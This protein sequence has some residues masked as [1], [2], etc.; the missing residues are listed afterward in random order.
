MA[1]IKKSITVEY[2]DNSYGKTEQKTKVFS[3]DENDDKQ[4][5]LKEI[6]EWRRD[7]G[8]IIKNQDKMNEDNFDYEHVED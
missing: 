6:E 7:N 2:E 8:F 4:L 5:V 1:H 3:T